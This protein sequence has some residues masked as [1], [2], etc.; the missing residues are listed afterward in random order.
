MAIGVALL[1]GAVRSGMRA[2]GSAI[3][4]TSHYLFPGHGNPDRPV[5]LIVS[6]EKTDLA[7]FA[8]RHGYLPGRWPAPALT[9]E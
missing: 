7:A 1:P 4:C 2:I 8:R 6:P 3:V 9:Q 5:T